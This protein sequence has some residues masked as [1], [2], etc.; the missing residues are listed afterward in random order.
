MQMVNL[1]LVE[2]EVEE[3]IEEVVRDVGIELRPLPILLNLYQ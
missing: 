2:E 1:G 3:E